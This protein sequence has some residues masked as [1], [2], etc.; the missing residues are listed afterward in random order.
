MKKIKI[1]KSGF[2]EKLKL[3]LIPIGLLIGSFTMPA[4]AATWYQ[5]NNSSH[6][7]FN[8]Y[9]TGWVS[10]PSSA[11]VVFLMGR[12]NSYGG[13]GCGSQAYRMSHIA[14]TKIW[15]KNVPSWG[16]GDGAWY[17]YIAFRYASG[18]TGW[19]NWESTWVTDRAKYSNT[20][21]AMTWNYDITGKTRLFTPQG[22]STNTDMNVAT[23]L[24]KYTAYLRVKYDEERSGTYGS[25]I[26]DKDPWTHGV[27][28]DFTGTYMT[29]ASASAQSTIENLD[30]N[31]WYDQG[32]WKWGYD[33][34]PVTGEVTFELKSIDTGFEVAGWAYSESATSP[35]Y[36]DNKNNPTFEVL[37]NTSYV[38]FIRRKQY[39]VTLNDNG[40]SGGSG[41]KT[42]KYDRSYSMTMSVS[43]PSKTG[44]S[45]QGYYTGQDGTGSM[46]INASGAWQKNVASYTGTDDSSN[47]KWIRDGDV[48]LYAKWTQS[49]TLDR[50]GGTTGSTSVTATYKSTTL[51]SFTNPGKTGYTFAGYYSGDNGTNQLIINTSQVLQENK[52]DVVAYTGADGKWIHDAA[53]TLY[54]KWTANPYTV[55]LENLG[56]DVGHKGTEN[57]SVTYDA[58]TNLTSAITKPEKTHY[59]FGGYYTS[60]DEGE[61]L[62]TQLID[63]NGNWKK[64]VSG[65]TGASSDDPTWVYAGDIT[66][67]AKWTETPYTITMAVSP[68]GAGTTSPASTATGKLVTES[69]NITATP[70]AGYKF[71]EWQFSKTGEDYDVW[72]ADG[73]SSTDVTIH[74]KAQ[75]NG[76]LTAVFEPRYYLVG[77]EIMSGEDE[78]GTGTSS[79]MPGW[80]NYNVPFNV[81]TS[82]PV[83][84]TCSLT[85]GANKHFYIMV[86]DKADGLSYGKSDETLEDNESLIFADQ[87]NRV[88]FHSNGGTAY[89]FKISAINGSGRPT[90]SVERPYQVNIGRKR[91]DIDG[92][93]HD[94]N[95]GGTV[96][97]SE[98]LS[99]DAILNGAWVPYGTSVKYDATKQ[100]G[101]TVDWYTASD[102]V[103]WF[104]N[105]DYW[106]HTATSTGNG[107]AKF[108]EVSTAVAL[109][110]DGHGHVEIGGD[111][112]TSTTCGVTTTR[113]ITAVA[114]DG[115]SFS[116]WTTSSTPDFE[117]DDTNEETVTLTGHGAGTAGTLTANFSANSYT[118]T[119]NDDHGGSNN[120]TATVDY[121]ATALTV[122]SH[123]TFSGWNLAGYFAE[124]TGDQ[125]T[126]ASGNLQASANGNNGSAYVITNSSSKWNHAG[127]LT[128]YAHWSRSVTLD[129]E[130]G[131]TGS[132]SVT[133]TYKGSTLSG[134][135]A[136]T[137]TGYN[138]AGYWTGDDGT[139]TE[140]INTSGALQANVS[141]YTNSDSQWTKADATTLYA[142]WT[143]K[144]YTA[145]NNIDKNGGDSHGTYTATY[146]AT[147]LVISAPEN[148]GFEVEDYY[149]DSGLN[150]KIADASGNLVELAQILDPATLYVSDHKWKYDN[151]D[152]VIYPKWTEK[153][154]TITLDANLP[155]T[156]TGTAGS[157]SFTA[158]YSTNTYSSITLPTAVG[159]TLAGYYTEDDVLIIQTDGSKK[160][161]TSYINSDGNWIHAGNI[162]LTAVWTPNPYTISLNNQSA[163]T[164]GSTSISVT[165]DAATN[166]T[167]TPAITVPASTGYT[168]GGYYTAVAGG[169]VQIIT[170]DGNVNAQAGGDNTYT[171]SSKEWKSPN[172]INLYAKWTQDITFNQNG[173]TVNGTTSLAATYNATLS[174]GSI[175]N[176]KKIGY[177]FAG[178]ATA[179]SDGTVVIAADGTVTASVSDWTDGSKNW[180][181][182]NA[183]TLYAT[184]TS[185]TKTF[186]GATDKD[187]AKSS[188]WSGGV[189]PTDDWSIVTIT[190]DADINDETSV[191]V[192]QVLIS[193]GTLTVQSGGSLEVAGTITK[194]NGDATETT[195]LRV[196]SDYSGQ[197][198][199][200]FDN[201]AGTTKATVDLFTKAMKSGDNYVF[202]MCAVPMT[203]V[204]VS[205]SFA[206]QGIYTYAWVEGTGWERRNYY[207]AVFA[208][209]AVA[210][211][212]SGD[213]FYYFFRGTLANTNNRS[214]SLK[215]TGT[216][217]D[218]SGANLF[219]NS[220]TAPIRIDKCSITGNADKTI[221]IY[222]NGDW[223]DYPT[224]SVGATDVIPA[225]QAYAVLIKEGS[226]GSLS[227]NYDQAVRG[228]P[229]ANRTE[230]LRAPKRT[231]QEGMSDMR[232]HV[233]GDERTTRLRLCESGLFTDEFDNGWEARYLEGDGRSGQLYAQTY[234][235]MSTLAV[236][237][238][239]GQVVGFIPGVASSYTISFEGDGEGYYLNDL[240]EQ[241][242]TLI[243]EGNTYVFTPNESTNATRFVISKMPIHKTT[244]G[245]DAIYDGTKARKQMIDGILYIIRDGR[246]YDATGV[247]VK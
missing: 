123:A 205:E 204:N 217:P 135:T 17:E 102:Y 213:R 27:K 46:V 182:A 69:G 70:A 174:T 76:T 201:S 88:L 171:N 41:S 64:S 196:S 117:V 246:I 107:Y 193:S 164:A 35:A 40:G 133:V 236:P 146:D 55:T 60:E 243:E 91:V 244:T 145:E 165:F 16:T 36:T 13:Q 113:S 62:G 198:A 63:A 82:S 86:R 218:A 14:H 121:D 26:S 247:L 158:K 71:K 112:E 22:S 97:M 94:D 160:T 242:S 28:F 175:V 109:S 176:P 21:Y 59:D 39:T 136:P 166:L 32:N 106:F 225:M 126:D 2:G 57:V 230:A 79:G 78:T 237:D 224:A 49:V 152:L 95:T 42:V 239:E 87:D 157:E 159:Y 195:D 61:T 56:A 232:I 210:L 192:G 11:T 54:A 53:T 100:T 98:T 149:Y 194:A 148:D 161:G 214:F 9:P 140:V 226:S 18:T 169:G 172:S 24:T 219:G 235:R 139:G 234:D 101:Y 181:H 103:T 120:G 128:L 228:V 187:W 67:Y 104:S 47:P 51:G 122:T 211:T 191:H 15:Y 209:E 125:V 184:W 92:N 96:A 33:Q 38:A 25:C 50:E 168:F 188:N 80:D 143:P 167:G 127:D 189:V 170:A 178:W 222:E 203:M 231:A 19:N 5:Q 207:Y 119:L 162:T 30:V 68:A 108:T 202:Q 89:T 190:S 212:Q 37:G 43:V 58:T 156:T 7:Y 132:E 77:G 90:V 163:T 93:D 74:I 138:F 238:L 129:R 83:L 31:G 186:T 229:V 8:D 151:T 99:G 12:N 10:D 240:D 144:T 183:S 115:Y 1:F 85:L 208:D 153:T 114:D 20:K 52:T 130:G 179:A 23:E 197:G 206:G 154:Y 44:Y 124:G 215:K 110:N 75:H 185:D 180:I 141:G 233:T 223:K 4:W 134:F 220:W 73:Y 142:K 177:A 34:I 118:V 6:V 216:D 84:A 137:K 245:N 147:K 150:Y 131:T 29:S 221:Y 48:T 155:A 105:A 116:S 173:A 45:F 81:V 227:I 3:L 200:I 199:L 241:E 72:C 65:Y 66:L 111:T